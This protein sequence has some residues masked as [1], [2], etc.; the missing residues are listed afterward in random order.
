MYIGFD[1]LLWSE[2]GPVTFS[3]ITTLHANDPF[4][5]AIV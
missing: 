2:V 3:L 5:F 4:R 1:P